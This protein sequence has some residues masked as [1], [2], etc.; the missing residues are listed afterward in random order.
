VLQSWL[1]RLRRLAGDP[2]VRPDLRDPATRTVIAGSI[3]INLLVLAIPLY[4]NRIYV[5]VL[6]QKAGDSLV[7]ITLLLA[8]VLVADVLL[9]GLR[10]WILSWMAAASEHRLRLTAVRSLLASDVSSVQAQPLQARLAA[11]RSVSL[12]RGLFEQQWLIRRVDLPFVLVYLLV[13]ALIGGWLVLLPLL[14]A[15]VFIH[16]AHRSAAA[17]AAALDQKHQLETALNETL[18]ASLGGAPTIK[19]FNLEGFLVRRLE[20]LQERLAEAGYHQEAKTARLQN[21]SALFA[22]LNQLLIVSCGA[23]L[24]MRQELSAGALAACTLLSGQI[25]MPLGKLFA[26]DGQQAAQVQA[27]LDFRDLQELPAE[28]NLLIGEMPPDQ[29][30]LELGPFS[31]SPG[32][33]MALL[34]GGPERSSRLLGSVTGISAPLAPGARYAG[35]SLTGYQR[36]QLRRRL[37][38]LV[39]A[40]GASA[41]TLLDN[42]TSFNAAERGPEAAE[43]CARHGVA[44]LI[45]A[46]PR[47]YDTPIGEQQ[48]FPLA[49][50]LLFRIQVIAA[51]LDQPAA[52]L[53]DASQLSIPADQLDWFL[54]LDCPAAR[55]VAVQEWPSVLPL[56]ARCLQWRGDLLEE[57]RA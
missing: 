40:P 20:P 1:H 4:I 28:P 56:P 37:R 9:K 23:L 35:Q 14:L 36:T 43:L 27:A 26:A 49:R 47:G 12:L 55:L 16:Y 53:L 51:L 54:N 19:T 32:D 13:L 22:Q 45:Q 6:P 34:G 30:L 15:P 38:L 33:R 57:V 8:V 39:P 25:T 29:G 21:F 10:A 48:D 42:L 41:G 24:V 11:L 5:S 7:V 46:L 31:L 44:L 3:A 50:G 52:L 17:M 2:G 18:H